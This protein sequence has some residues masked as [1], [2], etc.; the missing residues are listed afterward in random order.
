MYN[1]MGTQSHIITAIGLAGLIA[2]SSGIYLAMDAYRDR[3]WIAFVLSVML[4]LTG[5]AFLVP[6]E[7]N[8]WSAHVTSKMEKERDL[9]R[10]ANGRRLILDATADSLIRDKPARSAAKIRPDIDAELARVYYGRAL[11]AATTNCTDLSSLMIG[12]CQN[13]LALRREL[14]TAEDYEKKAGLVW[15]AN[16][17][18]G[19]DTSETHGTNDGPVQLTAIFGGTPERWTLILT[20]LTIFFMFFVRGFAIY[21]GWRKAPVRGAV[22]LPFQIVVR[23]P[24]PEVQRS[25][26]AL[27]APVAEV[28]STP[29]LITPDAPAMRPSDEDVLRRVM[30]SLPYGT[31]TRDE[32]ESMIGAVCLDLGM[33]KIRE[34]RTTKLLVA[35]GIKPVKNDKDGARYFNHLGNAAVAPKRV[36]KPARKPVK[37]PAKL[38]LVK[39]S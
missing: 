20:V 18:I 14:A 22:D 36:R 27:A 32:L 38:R 3:A 12:R 30:A 37:K 28:N 2:A 35:L 25:L 29:P 16:S 11:G 17:A 4:W 31:I 33:V 10:Q 8:Y 24:E 1:A 7:I 19:V 21:L 26:P 13:V 23:P 34:P 5:E 15:E 39:A 6:S 9:G